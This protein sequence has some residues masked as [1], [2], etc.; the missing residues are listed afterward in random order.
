MVRC[1]KF[2]I[3]LSARMDGA[4]TGEEELALEDHLAHCPAC[5]A[6]AADL[7]AL[8]AAFAD[9]E[10]VPAPEGFAQGV[11]D[12]IRAQE[13][14]KPK[15][16][17]LFRRPQ[18]RAAAGLAACAL[19]CVGLY[20]AGILNGA[21]GGS[22]QMSGAG[23]SAA[24]ATAAPAGGYQSES[25]IDRAAS[26]ERSSPPELYQEEAAPQWDA[27][28]KQIVQ[29]PDVL[30]AAGEKSGKCVDPKGADGAAGA[31]DGSGETDG[32]RAYTAGSG[33]EVAGQGEANG[34]AANEIPPLDGMDAVSQMSGEGAA[35]GAA[36]SEV[37]AEGASASS[38]S[39]EDGELWHRIGD[40][41]V[42]AVLTMEC[43]P[44]GAE[45]VLEGEP[46]WLPDGEGASFC[47]ITGVEMEELMALAAAQELSCQATNRIS[48]EQVC[49]LR[50]TVLWELG[51]GGQN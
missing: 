40:R 6:L 35:D 28:D 23:Y 12:Q 32:P 22:G 9:L 39:S 33:G 18:M 20:Q 25:E 26:G 31:S 45:E 17:P 10:E 38:S 2:E 13:S 34:A 8:H 16:V 7:D 29:A 36:P 37:D 27:A 46:E 15:V 44:Q 43:L 24:G 30:P 5:R 47:L 3:M 14:Q 1:E 41:Q 49:A 50:L 11:M 21:S 42:N 51:E 4:L 48:G 19:L